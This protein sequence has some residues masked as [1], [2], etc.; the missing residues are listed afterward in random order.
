MVPLAYKQ[1]GVALF[2]RAE[3]AEAAVM[4]SKALSLKPQNVDLLSNLAICHLEL[5]N[6]EK[7]T[8]AV[9]NA[10]R[11]EENNPRALN[12]LG[13]IYLARHQYPEANSV[14]LKAMKLEPGNPLRVFNLAVSFDKLEDTS[15][16]CFLWRRFMALDVSE[17][18]DAEIIK[19]LADIGCPLN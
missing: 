11:I 14:F 12:T 17:D 8:Q 10:L 2:E 15:Q 5:G 18:Y 19:H 1:L 3:Y 16:A 9:E 7:A 4:M 13:E 6:L